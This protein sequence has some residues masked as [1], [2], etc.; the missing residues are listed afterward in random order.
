MKQALNTAISCLFC[1]LLVVAHASLQAV[2]AEPARPVYNDT[3]FHAGAEGLSPSERAGREIWYKAT[4]GNDRFHT[5]V[6]QQR[7]GVLIDWWRVLRSDERDERFKVW[8]LVNN[9]GCC[10]P[11]SPGCPAKSMEETYGFDWCYGDDELLRYVGQSGYRDPACDF[12]DAPVQAG[13]P[14]GSDDKRESACNLAFG[15]STGAMGLRKFP[16]PKFDAER[17]RKL[18]GGNLG[19]WMGFSDKL[20]TDPKVSDHKVSHLADG[21]VEPPFLIG[22]ACGAC[23]IAPNPLNPPADVANPKWENLLGAIGN[24]YSRLSELMVSGM[25]S[26]SLQWQV[27]SHTRPGVVDTSAVPTDQI[28]NPGTINALINVRQRPVFENEV[29]N[30]WRPVDACRNDTNDRQCW[31]E[32]GKP[33]KCWNKSVEKETVFHVLKG[34]GDSIGALGA[35]QRVYISIGSCSEQ[36]WVNHLTDLYQLDP[37]QRNYGQT[38][39]DMGQCRRDC[40][41]FRAIEDRAQNIVDFLLSEKASATELF[42]AK[43]HEDVGDLIDELELE[44]GEGAVDRGRVLFA[45][46]CARCHSTQKEPF[47][48]KDFRKVSATTGLREDWMGNDQA[49]PASEI[50]SFHCRAL[51]SNHMQGHI[52]EEFASET[53]RERPADLNLPDETGGGRGYFRNVSLV[54]LWAHAPFLHNNAIGPELCGKPSD[55]SR[56]FYRSPYVNEEGKRLQNP[57]DCWAYDPSVEGRFELFKASLEA[58]LNPDRRIPKVTLLDEPIRR[59]IG[60]KLWDGEKEK[61]LKGI[62]LEIPAGTPSGLFGSFQHKE[63]LR[64]LI[65]A[66]IDKD[67][68]GERMAA[69]LGPDE[70]KRAAKS[71]DGLAK[72]I[73]KHPDQLVQAGREQLPLLVKLYSTCSS[74][75]ENAGHRFG[76]DLSADDK[77]ALT[78]FLATL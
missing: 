1:F 48:T 36:C 74:T 29:V 67:K 19:A 38:A 65:L 73:L 40:P 68:L 39:M 77:R 78:A 23:H 34:G 25:P 59:D 41:N 70:A 55:P 71:I 51:H 32:P 44:F 60:P 33:G 12:E 27:F 11:G 4:A 8:G 20:S 66:L 75:V 13:H 18:N 63:F 57:P 14:H 72:E 28:N 76:E 47:E 31:C 54:D 15:T 49:T 62:S 6:F 17:W 43:G 50:G 9:P 26:D 46:N 5:Y 2:S 22:M 30:R 42:A 58:L 52:W 21:S 69:R 64:D 3:G 37:N 56:D 53:Y 10:Q 35:V 16:N 45:Q 7:M 24:Q 61:R